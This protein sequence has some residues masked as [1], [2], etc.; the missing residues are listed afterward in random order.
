MTPVAPATLPA[1]V[2]IA[3]GRVHLRA[4]PTPELAAAIC[5]DPRELIRTLAPPAEW[6]AIEAATR[7]PHIEQLDIAQ[8]RAAGA[9]VAARLCGL[10][11]T[12]SGWRT[13]FKLCAALFHEPPAGWAIP[14]SVGIDPTRA[15]LWVVTAAIWA[16]VAEGKKD[17]Q[18]AEFRRE[19]TAPL[20]GEA[21]WRSAMPIADAPAVDPRSRAER[22]KRAHRNRGAV[23]A[24]RSGKLR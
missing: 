10:E 1:V 22:A 8:V 15:P 21:Y 23:A 13:A 6:E 18:L 5:D 12:M 19:I 7:S 16:R 9:G 17:D 24:L 4:L 11:P 3:G 14:V 20:P 2:D